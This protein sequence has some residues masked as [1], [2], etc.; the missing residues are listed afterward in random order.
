M[1]AGDHL[2]VDARSAGAVLFAGLANSVAL[3]SLALAVRAAPVASVNT[4]S[5]SSIVFSFIASV[6][7]FN[8]TGSPPMIAGIALVTAG[9]V[10]AQLRR[11]GR[12]QAQ[13]DESVAAAVGEGE[14]YAPGSATR[15]RPASGEV[16]CRK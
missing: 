5:S 15:Q 6:V 8:E 7:V 16:N 4:I 9:I 13:T 1:L 11:R 3:A 12:D 14:P 10:V 2:V